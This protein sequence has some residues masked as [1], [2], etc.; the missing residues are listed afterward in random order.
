ML[1]RQAIVDED[2]EMKEYRTLE[3]FWPY[4]LK[5]H[6]HPTTKLLHFIG[7]G[8]AGGCLVR[9]GL[10]RDPK[11]VV[12]GLLCGYGCAWVSHF[13]VEKNKPA[14]FRYPLFSLLSDFRLFGEI[15]RG[16]H[17]IL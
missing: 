3:E 1:S 2:D 8:L 12:Y 7:T 9:L 11:N 16:K 13:F 17:R 15:L 10:T 14:T 6:S 4:Y 5:E